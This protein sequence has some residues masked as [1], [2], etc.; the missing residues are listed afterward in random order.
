MDFKSSVDF[1][2]YIFYWHMCISNIIKDWVLVIILP[3][4]ILQLMNSLI[5][6]F[7]LFITHVNRCINTIQ[8]KNIAFM[9]H[10]FKKEKKKLKKKNKFIRKETYK[11]NSTHV[12]SQYDHQ[13]LHIQNVRSVVHTFIALR[14]CFYFYF[15]K[16]FNDTVNLPEFEFEMRNQ[17]YSYAISFWFVR[18]AH[19]STNDC[20]VLLFSIF[21]LLCFFPFSLY[22][23]CYKNKS[24]HDGWARNYSASVKMP[25]SFHSSH[26]FLCGRN[27]FASFFS[28]M[29]RKMRKI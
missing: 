9:F 27:T 18:M 3:V 5:W 8:V 12:C 4:N 15:H 26:N 1:A 14:R 13:Q 10:L 19:S 24:C 29:E 6:Q 20:C 2:L 25:Y 28:A 17:L 23:S 7:S 22:D 16:Y 21:F 11:A